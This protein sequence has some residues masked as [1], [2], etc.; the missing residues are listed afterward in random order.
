MVSVTV[1]VDSVRLVTVPVVKLGVTAELTGWTAP[2]IAPRISPNP[3]ALLS[4]LS[5]LSVEHRQ[6]DRALANGR[7]SSAASS[8]GRNACTTESTSQSSG[9]STCRG[10]GVA[11]QVR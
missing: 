9:S 7:S 10:D 1:V 2:W 3:I 4:R 11:V 5:I 8:D 6:L